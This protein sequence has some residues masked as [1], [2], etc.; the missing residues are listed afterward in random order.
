MTNKKVKCACGS[1]AVSGHIKC[2][3]CF[4]LYELRSKVSDLEFKARDDRTFTI[5]I[6][7]I[8]WIK[9]TKAQV[10]AFMKVDPKG[11][12]IRFDITPTKKE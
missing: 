9:C 2:S 12:W 7:E 1:F 10:D 6:Q 11:N 4:E 8:N 5:H 3:R